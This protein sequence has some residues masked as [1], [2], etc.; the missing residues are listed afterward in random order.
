MKKKA[1]KKPRCRHSYGPFER[2]SDEPTPYQ[3]CDKCGVTRFKGERY[4][5]GSRSS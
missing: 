4:A 2:P 5:Y 3:V 1:K